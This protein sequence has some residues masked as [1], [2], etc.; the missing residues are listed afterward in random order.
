MAEVLSGLLTLAGSRPFVADLHPNSVMIE[1]INEEFPHHCQDLQLHSFY[2][3]KAMNFGVKRIVVPKDSAIMGYDN[4]RS[5]FLANANHREV[6]KFSSVQEPNYLTVRNAIATVVSGFR[7]LRPLKRQESNSS[8][9]LL[10]LKECLDIN[11]KYD[12]DF[13]RIDAERVPG[14]C[15]WITESQSFLRWRDHPAT[16]LYWLAAKPGTGK[17]ILSAFLIGHLKDL[18][19]SCSFYFFTYDDKSKF[20]LSLLLLS[21]AWQMALNHHEV[22][23]CITKKL[24]KDPHLTASDHRTIWRK[25]FL[26]GI[27]KLSLTETQYVVIDALDECKNS[28]ELV[29][30]MVKAAELNCM[31]IFLTSRNTFETYAGHRP[32]HLTIFSEVIPEESTTTDIGIYINANLHSL[33]T[34]GRDKD[35]AREDLTEAILKKSSGCFLWVR[36]VLN[37]LRN[38]HTSEEIQRVLE[39]IPSDMDKLYSRILDS[40]L[41]LK[42]GKALTQAILVWTVCA[43]QPLTTEELHEALELDIND[44]VDSVERSISTTCGELVYVD[45]F[46]RV[47]MVHQTAREFLLRPDNE[48]EFA[49]IRKHGHE[50]LAMVCLKYLGGKEMNGRRKWKLGSTTSDMGIRDRSPF[51]AYAA[52]SLADHITFA[53]SESDEFLFALCR[54]FNSH[55]IFLWIEF[56]ARNSDLQR[57]IKTGRALKNYLSRRSKKFAPI[58][59]DITLLDAWATDLLRLVTKFGK[60]LSLYPAS[61]H[62]LIPPFCPSGTAIRSQFSNSNRSMTIKGLCATTW[63][64]CASIITYQH[65]IP[66]TVACSSSSFAIGQRSGRIKIHDISS[67]QELGTLTHGKP[68][69]FLRY[70][71]HGK[72]FA[73]VALKSICVWDVTSWEQVWMFDIELP[74]RD[75]CFVENDEALV[76]TLNGDRIVAWDLTTGICSELPSWADD[77][78]PEYASGS[79]LAVTI[80][81]DSKMLAVAYRGQDVIVWDLENECVHGIYG[82]DIGLVGTMGGKRRGVCEGT[83]LMFSPEPEQGLL[84]VGYGTG[85][86]VVFKTQDQTIQARANQVNAQKMASS[87]DGLILA[88]STSAGVILIFEFE[89]LKLLYRIV[90]E[91]YTIKD[92]VFTTDGHRLIDIRGPY[93]RIWDPPILLH[94]AWTEEHNSDTVSTSTAVQDYLL[95]DTGKNV[96][97]TAL[98]C[99]NDDEVIVC[100]KMDGSICMYNGKTGDKTKVLAVSSHGASITHL[101]Y[102]SKS[103]ILTSVDIDNCLVSYQLS[104][105][106]G[107]WEATKVFQHRA[108]VPVTQLLVN[109]GCTRIMISSRNADILCAVT[110][111]GD[112]VEA[113]IRWPERRSYQWSTHPTDPL[114]LILV[115]DTTAHI[116]EWDSLKRLT[117]ET[118]IQ[119]AGSLLP[120]LSIRAL[121]S[122][123]DGQIMATMFSETITSR[124]RSKLFLW[125]TS[126]FEHSNYTTTSISQYQPLADEIKFI[127]GTHGHLLVFLHHDGWVC[128]ADLQNFS[129]EFFDRHFPLP[130]DW[131]TATGA[132]GLMLGIFNRLG[133]IRVR[134]L[135]VDKQEVFD[136]EYTVILIQSTITYASSKTDIIISTFILVWFIYVELPTI[137]IEIEPV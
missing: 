131:L 26:D 36:L 88:C 94:N 116:Y 108:G 4:E 104:R 130:A 74:I 50:R 57:L 117:P 34:L 48:S 18:K 107:T 38:T 87:P 64:D 133:T 132:T 32:E 114:R 44:D 121:N 105:D 16:H 106:E 79:P 11:E 115:F 83:C 58:G 129:I 103:R 15:T 120:E 3:T 111:D 86:L 80:G 99:M 128:S 65:E 12:D 78:D 42:R 56:I 93:C 20:S 85:D 113:T 62:H 60:T 124:S 43:A 6:C 22:F 45:A 59:R 112:H 69:K 8:A 51:A 24:E 27:F 53:S 123:F 14:S 66:T 125:H 54:F 102:D 73:S 19:K 23:L 81:G 119:L 28:A 39:E 41:D 37:E 134:T 72:F 84:A 77:L 122:C 52:N 31:R 127:I 118:G 63:D 40:M 89:T 96:L 90:S 137:H 33:P 75:L 10:L 100:G 61:I 25:L 126:D 2:E 5:N 68:V 13:R 29:P 70:S 98:V 47:Q 9:H 30:L 17:S 1:S 91:E 67:C 21:I 55:K 76:G 46:S 92:L 71:S 49:I 101:S 136:S 7:D 135:K 110:T 97:I 82:Q 109:P 35:K 95:D